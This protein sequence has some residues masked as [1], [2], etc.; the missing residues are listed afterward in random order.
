MGAGL[1]RQEIRGLWRDTEDSESSRELDLSGTNDLTSD[2]FIA[3]E[4]KRAEA[5]VEVAD[6]ILRTAAMQLQAAKLVSNH[7]GSDPRPYLSMIEKST[8][9]TALKLIENR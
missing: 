7:D 4:H 8:M 1:N 9:G 6:Q 2:A 5:M 3:S